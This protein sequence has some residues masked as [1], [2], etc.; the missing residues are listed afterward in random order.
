MK[1]LFV[2]SEALPF[3]ASGGL[4]DVMGSLP[5]AIRAQDPQ[6]MDVRVV[7]P[8]YSSIRGEYREKMTF[9]KECSVPLAWRQ[10]YCGIWQY[11]REGVIYYFLDNEYYFKRDSLYG[12]FDDAERY[13]YFSRAVLEMMREID[14]Y[15]D[16]LHANDWQSALTLI[17]LRTKYACYQ[18]YTGIRTVYTIHNI[19]YQGV[20]GQELLGDIFDLGE[21]ERSLVDYRGD[22]NLTKGAIVCCDALTTVS[23]HYAEEIRDPYFANGLHYITEQYAYKTRGIVNGIDTAYY[24]PANKDD[25]FA[26]FTLRSAV[27][28]KRKNKLELQRRMGLPESEGTPVI[29][30]VSRLAAH[31]GF[32]LVKCVLEQFIAANDVQFVLLG[33]GE[34][35]F[36][37]YFRYLAE[38]YPERVACRFLFDKALSKQ[39]YAG[40]DLFLMPSKS[41]PCGLSQMIA[42]RYGAVPI[43][44]EV[45]GLYDTIHAY[46]PA[47]KT[48]NGITFYS[49]NAYDMLDAIRRAVDLYHGDPEGF[50]ALRRNA[51]KADFSWDASA[52][53]YL[54]LYRELYRA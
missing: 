49:Y 13:A 4:G 9:V 44:R 22:I 37:A 12:S 18:P 2:G 25:L 5:M 33:T 10:L 46:Q 11:E 8:L 29:A 35:D 50:K 20:Y 1:I 24:D 39:I 3:A 53:G 30:M 47:E 41:E 51:M 40:A 32:D 15:P 23:P 7:M 16:V 54:A 43:V 31:K 26:P 48:G 38:R 14:F 52:S 17:Y 21:G 27:T 42:S 45:G 36:E 34:A 19:D 28:G 6:T